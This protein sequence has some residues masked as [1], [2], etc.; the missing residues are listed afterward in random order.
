MGIGK[1]KGFIVQEFPNGGFGRQ[2]VGLP[3][4]NINIANWS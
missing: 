4:Q 2:M 3:K 1:M